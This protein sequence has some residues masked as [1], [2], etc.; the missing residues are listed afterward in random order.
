MGSDTLT[1]GY[2][3]SPEEAKLN[4]RDVDFGR[5]YTDIHETYFTRTDLKME[6]RNCVDGEWLSDLRIYIYV[7]DNF[8]HDR[9]YCYVKFS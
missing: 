1:I 2:G 5:E 4:M 8:P 6:M 9:E 7:L 3:S